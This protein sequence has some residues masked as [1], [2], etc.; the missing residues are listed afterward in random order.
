MSR[1]AAN[2]EQDG[3]RDALA[4]VLIVEVLRWTG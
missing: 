1:C 3:G 2:L 4:V